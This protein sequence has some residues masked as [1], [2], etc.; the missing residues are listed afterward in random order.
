MKS[1]LDRIP[2]FVQLES[3][4]KVHLGG[5]GLLGGV[6]NKRSLLWRQAIRPDPLGSIYSIELRSSDASSPQVLVVDPDLRA[7]ADGRKLPHIYK[8]IDGLVHLCLNCRGDWNPRRLISQ[9]IVVW[10]AEWFLFFEYWLV[11]DVWLGGG[12][13]PTTP[14]RPAMRRAD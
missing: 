9:T 3:L 13:H 1:R 6:P 11:N 8:D 7:L 5:K 12:T 14:T 4:R 2:L 10:A